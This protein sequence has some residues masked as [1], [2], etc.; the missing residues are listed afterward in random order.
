M[1]RFTNVGPAVHAYQS[2]LKAGSLFVNAGQVIDAPGQLAAEQP[3]DAY[4]VGEGDDARLWP[5][6][7]GRSWKTSP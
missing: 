4:Q 2:S 7:S 6:P 5:T 3:G 1:P